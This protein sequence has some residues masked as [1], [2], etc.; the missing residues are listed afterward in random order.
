MFEK[1]PF[2]IQEQIERLQTRGLL[3]TPEDN[4]AHYLSHISYYRLGEYWHSMQSDKVNHIFKENSKFKDVIALYQF[5][6]ERAKTERKVV[7]SSL[8]YEIF[9]R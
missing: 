4:A 9:I 3:I 6:G 8:H 1:L 7:C 2:T 5:D